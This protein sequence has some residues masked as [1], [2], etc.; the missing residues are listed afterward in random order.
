M[1]SLLSAVSH[2]F[3]LKYVPSRCFTSQVGDGDGHAR[4]FLVVVTV[5]AVVASLPQEIN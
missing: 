4:K 2:I 1:S 3:L 5:V